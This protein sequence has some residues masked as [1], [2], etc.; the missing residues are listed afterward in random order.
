MKRRRAWPKAESTYLLRISLIDRPVYRLGSAAVRIVGQLPLTPHD[1]M[2]LGRISA[3]MVTTVP[4]VKKSSLP[5]K[6][7]RA[8]ASARMPRTHDGFVHLTGS[9]PVLGSSSSRRIRALSAPG[10]RRLGGA[11]N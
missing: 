11:R 4:H 1:S 5:A 9:W 7:Q 8:S 6:S 10:K 2:S 3:T